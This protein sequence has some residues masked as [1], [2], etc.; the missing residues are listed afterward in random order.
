LLSICSL[1]RQV[2]VLI[3]D[4]LG[5]QH[6][7]D[8]ANRTG[9]GADD[10]E[11][12]LTS[13][14]RNLLRETEL[15]AFVSKTAL[16]DAAPPTGPWPFDACLRPE[17]PDD[18]MPAAW[19]SLAFRSVALSRSSA[20]RSAVALGKSQSSMNTKVPLYFVPFDITDKGLRFGELTTAALAPG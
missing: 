10:V 4:A 7:I 17:I 8:A 14:M 13:V 11:Q 18:F 3:V 6:Y 20:T 2:R 9:S 16:F 5:V 15:T 12:A 19:R 1:P